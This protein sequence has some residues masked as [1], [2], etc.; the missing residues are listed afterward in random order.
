MLSVATVTCQGCP[1]SLLPWTVRDG[2]KGGVQSGG[3][4]SER[5]SALGICVRDV[6]D[7]LQVM[8]EGGCH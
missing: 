8:G 2:K 7:G 1:S 6:H 3:A 5:M 4:G